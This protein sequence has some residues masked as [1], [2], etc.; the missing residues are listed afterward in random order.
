MRPKR[1]DID[2]T[3]EDVDGYANDDASGNGGAVTLTVTTPTDGLAHKVV[4]TP[5]GSVTGNYTLVG[6]DADSKAITET[7]A[8]NTTNAVTSTRFFKTL[9]SMTNASG[10][11]AETIDVGWADEVASK[12]IPLDH[13]QSSPPVIQVDVTG[14]INY[15]IEVT[16]ENP[17]PNLNDE[18]AAPFAVLEQNDLTW[19]NDGN[20]TAKTADLI[21]DLA[22]EGMRAMRIVINSYSSGAELQIHINQPY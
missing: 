13:Y 10:V 2:V 6:T 1:I 12:T 18:N 4:V 14:T 21:D 7:L 3:D 22:V 8:T 11:G 17:Y 15:D 9:T 19:V 20:F 16:A 5:S